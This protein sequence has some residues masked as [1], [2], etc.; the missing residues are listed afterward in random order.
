MTATASRTRVSLEQAVGWLKTLD[1]NTLGL[2]ADRD[3]RRRFDG[4]A[5]YRQPANLVLGADPVEGADEVRIVDVHPELKA[6]DVYRHMAALA[7]GGCFVEGLVTS[8]LERLSLSPGRLKKA[9]LSRLLGPWCETFHRGQRQIRGEHGWEAGLA[10]LR[11]AAVSGLRLHVSLRYGQDE[12]PEMLAQR[13]L[14][15][16]RLQDDTARVDALVLLPHND[17]NQRDMPGEITTGYDDMRLVAT[18]RLVLD[19]VP[20]IQVPWLP[21]GLKAA[22]LGLV[23]GGDD[24]GPWCLDP[25]VTEAAHVATYLSLRQEEVLMA[26][27][28]AG[29]TPILWK[30]NE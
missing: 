21:F 14:D 15:V 23:F 27:R 2:E 13:L 28:D 17:Q 6:A 1:V 10:A 5:G 11:D 7:A 3:S 12:T 30:G 9:G 8:D 16:R 4:R 19:N 25:G 20:H 22:Q 26:I 29:R 24:L 18:A